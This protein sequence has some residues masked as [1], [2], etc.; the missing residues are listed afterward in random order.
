[1]YLDRYV[2]LN[3]SFYDALEREVNRLQLNDKSAQIYNIDESYFT[4]DPSKGK[5]VAATGSQNIQ[6]VVAGTG[7]Q[8][9]TVMACVSADGNREPPLFIFQGKHH[10]SSWRG[11]S[12]PE[13][14]TYAISKKGWM[15]T[16]IF[17]EWFAKFLLRVHH[18]P[19]LIIFD[20][21]ASHVGLDV[22]S[23]AR[24]ADVSLLR[25]PAHTS[26]VL[27]PLDISCF[28][29]LKTKWNK[30]LIKEQRQNGHKTLSK[31]QFVDLVCNVW[32]Q[33][34][35]KEN[36]QSG[37]NS[38]GIFPVDR[39]KFPVNKFHVGKLK[40]YNNA[41]R[42]PC[43]T[44]ERQAAEVQINNE[45]P[46]QSG[47]RQISEPSLQHITEIVNAALLNAKNEILSSLT[48]VAVV[49]S[50]KSVEEVRT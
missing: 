29:P 42:Q 49:Q 18:R 37:F 40:E 22:I 44:G 11:T 9:Y 46:C 15:T 31:S 2:F 34:L 45:K 23:L 47:D 19:L 17:K 35:T 33:S 16:A 13:N 30:S 24:D 25:L 8:N 5:I 3:F 21:H 43:P 14:T 50:Q 39:T 6:R 1:L 7:R 38:R 32:E 12:A 26:H 41:K 28:G 20:G 48:N 27:Q 4:L 36:V 10:Y